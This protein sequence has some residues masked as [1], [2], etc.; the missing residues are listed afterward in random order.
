MS[1][2]QYY[3]G[4]SGS[5]YAFEGIGTHSTPLKEDWEFRDQTESFFGVQGEQEIRDEVHG[6]NF[7]IQADFLGY[8][9]LALLEADLNTIDSKINKLTGRLSVNGQLYDNIVFKGFSR[10]STPQYMG[11]TNPGWGMIGGWLVWRQL[12]P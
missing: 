10:G 7:R 4:I 3:K 8:A 5:F 6:R 2:S 11:G 1:I 12:R 9:T